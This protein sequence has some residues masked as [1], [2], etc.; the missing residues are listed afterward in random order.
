MAGF[1]EVLKHSGNY[2]LANLATRALAFISIPVYT[3]VLSTEDYGITA[4]FL[5][6]VGILNGLIALNFDT[7]VSRYYYDKTSDADFK[8]FVGTSLISATIAICL[9][10]ALIYSFAH[11]LSALTSLPLKTIYLLVPMAVVN[12][13]GLMFIQIYQP[14]K[15]SKAIALS[16]LA[17]VYLG[18]VFSIGLIFV[19]KSEKYFGQILGQILAGGAMLVYWIRKISPYVALTFDVQHLKYILHYSIPLIPYTLSGVVIEQF[20]KLTIASTEGVAQAGFYTLAVS[21]ASLTA[22]VTEIT[23]MAWYPYYM[24]YMKSGNYERHDSD[25]VR[26]FKLTLVAAMF[27]SCFGQEIG[28]IL[29]KRDFTSALYLVPIITLGYVCHQLAY[30]YMRNLSFALKTSYMSLIVISAG[31]VNILLNSVMI[32]RWGA[33]GA[34]VAFALSYALMA[35][36][37]WIFST[38]VAKVRGISLCLLLRPLGLLTFFLCPLYF[39]F[40]IPGFWLPFSAK[41]LLFGLLACVLFWND[42]QAVVQI[43]RRYLFR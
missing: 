15:Q 26:I 20:G 4:V 29:A 16:S 38:F 18:F 5:S 37:S 23:H 1:K 33:S 40:R 35:G 34:A 36:L 13:V 25:L 8:T 6:A 21:I 9:T 32:S 2:L 28:L 11:R 30:A 19:F 43:L 41:L 3:R 17:R 7:S 10:S 31:C 42:R 22:I 14:L 39:I 12:L 27:F 24:E